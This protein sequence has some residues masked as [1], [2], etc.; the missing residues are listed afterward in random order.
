M[1][2]C[3]GYSAVYMLKTIDSYTLNGWIVWELYLNKAV[4][5]WYCTNKLS[6]DLFS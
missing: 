5:K 1:D 6:L 3:D 4:I 2:S